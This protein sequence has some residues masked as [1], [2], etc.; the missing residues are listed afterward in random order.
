MTKPK[1]SVCVTAFNHEKYIENCLESILL[2]QT[3]FDFE[4][5]VHDDASQDGTASII[6]EYAKRH[7][8]LIIPIL[9]TKNCYSEDGHAPLM[10]CATM[11]RG[12]YLAICEGD[13]Y[14]LESDKLKIQNEVLDKNKK[15]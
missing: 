2:Q 5:I 15:A 4:I 10:N 9:Q 14:W 11:A 8:S 7:P 3:N 12:E 1:I 13:D 6:R